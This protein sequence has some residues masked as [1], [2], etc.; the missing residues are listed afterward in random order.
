[1]RYPGPDRLQL[2]FGAGAPRGEKLNQEAL[3]QTAMAELRRIRMKLHV[4][5]PDRIKLTTA[6]ILGRLR[7]VYAERERA[8]TLP[9]PASPENGNAGKQEDESG[10]GRVVGGAEPHGLSDEEAWRLCGVLAWR[11]IDDGALLASDALARL[12]GLPAD[13]R[14]QLARWFEAKAE[15]VQAVWPEKKLTKNQSLQLVALGGNWLETVLADEGMLAYT[16]ERLQRL[17]LQAL[18]LADD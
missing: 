15:T 14:W 16:L 10:P 3:R 12:R 2:A 4:T 8:G 11:L 18:V 17:D 7:A 5:S 1:M 9:R 6:E 13:K